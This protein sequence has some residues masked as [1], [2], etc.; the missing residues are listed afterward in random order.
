MTMPWFAKGSLTA[1]E[2]RQSDNLHGAD[3]NGLLEKITDTSD[4]WD[5]L[6]YVLTA[7][8]D[9]DNTMSG[10]CLCNARGNGTQGAVH[11]PNSRSSG[12]PLQ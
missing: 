11:K 9:H 8:G 2:E 3:R 6:W 12:L 1:S 4:V 10:K 5:I 7:T